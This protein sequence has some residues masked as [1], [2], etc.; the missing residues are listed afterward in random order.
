MQ[1]IP[2]LT[3]VFLTPIH[4][5]LDHPS[6]FR[7]FPEVKIYKIKKGSKKKR[8]KTRS[9]PRN[10]PRKWS[11]KKKFFLF[12]L[13]AFLVESVFSFLFSWPLSFFSFFLNRFLGRERVFFLS[14]SFF[15]SRFL[16]RKRAC[17]VVYFVRMYVHQGAPLSMP[18]Q[19][20][21]NCYIPNRTGKMVNVSL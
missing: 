4:H 18:D 21:Y 17:L 20:F 1:S 13:A 11:R 19:L 6:K 5:S 3:S 8:K 14:F 9:R 10:R 16:G 2:W 7:P 15:L 12:F